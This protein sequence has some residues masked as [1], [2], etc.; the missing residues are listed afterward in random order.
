MWAAD[1][2][3]SPAGPWGNNELP[4]APT[5]SRESACP[6][7]RSRK[8]LAMGLSLL[9]LVLGLG[10]GD[11]IHLGNES[12]TVDNGRIVAGFWGVRVSLIA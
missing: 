11:L 7:V 10:E 12:Y 9:G 8:D 2:E 3:A 6:P 5:A 1:M 4:S